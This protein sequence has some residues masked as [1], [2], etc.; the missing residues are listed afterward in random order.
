MLGEFSAVS[1]ILGEPSV[2]AG[3]GRSVWEAYIDSEHYSPSQ[4]RKALLS[5]S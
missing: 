1:T 5:P 4:S 3:A 2:S